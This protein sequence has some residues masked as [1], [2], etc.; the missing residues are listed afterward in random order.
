[1]VNGADPRTGAEQF[2]EHV[3]SVAL[4]SSKFKERRAAQLAPQLEILE[5]REEEEEEEEGEED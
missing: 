4:R 2:P 3:Q 5:E 1:V